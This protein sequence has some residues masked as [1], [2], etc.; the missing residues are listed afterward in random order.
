MA[1][2]P[3][4]DPLTGKPI[5]NSTS[6]K[7]VWCGEADCGVCYAAA[8]PEIVEVVVSNITRPNACVAMALP[9]YSHLDW[10]VSELPDPNGTFYLGHNR[11]GNI[12]QGSGGHCSWTYRSA[13]F[14]VDMYSGSGCSTVAQTV[15]C[16]YEYLLDGYWLPAYYWRFWIDVVRASDDSGVD[17]VFNDT[18]SGTTGYDCDTNFPSFTNGST[19]T[20]FSGGTATLALP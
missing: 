12:S 3:R 18:T 13:T 11:H 20:D 15:S 16:Y 7:P 17:E 2:E 5:Y 1:G 10:N 14:D 6:G 4:Y 9:S 8:S 19:I